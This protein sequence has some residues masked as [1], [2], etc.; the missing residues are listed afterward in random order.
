V[1]DLIEKFG[2]APNLIPRSC[3]IFQN[4]GNYELLLQTGIIPELF[5]LVRE[6]NVTF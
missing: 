2:N 3:D 5:S 4:F 1:G 6:S